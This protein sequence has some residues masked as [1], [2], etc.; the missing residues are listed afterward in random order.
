MVNEIIVALVKF[1]EYWFE[2]EIRRPETIADIAQCLLHITSYHYDR[3]LQ[4]HSDNSRLVYTILLKCFDDHTITK[5]GDTGLIIRRACIQS[6]LNYVHCI[7]SDQL[8]NLIRLITSEAA[9]NRGFTFRLSMQKLVT[10]FHFIR[11]DSRHHD[12]CQSLGLESNRILK[13]DNEI[14]SIE[15]LQLFQE[16]LNLFHCDKLV[17]DLWRGLVL[18]VADPNLE[19]HCKCIIDYIKDCR[20]DIRQKLLEQYLILA[21]AN[22]RCLR[23]S[24]PLLISMNTILIRLETCRQFQDNAAKFAWRAS[25]KTSNPR[26]YFLA[27]DIFCT[28][29]VFGRIN[30][31]QGYLYVLLGHRLAVKIRSYTATQMYAAILS[32]DIDEPEKLSEIAEILQQTDWLELNE[33]KRE[34]DKIRNLMKELPSS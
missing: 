10:I 28:L 4:N 20:N 21:E 23:L 15:D 34:R 24:I 19:R 14:D 5:K 11:N 26:K 30:L 12:L 27:C 7:D 29:L 6:C 31:V 33:A 9:S 3:L 32:L 2:N 16:L 13:L 8:L 25:E 22:A 17:I 1:Q 18:I